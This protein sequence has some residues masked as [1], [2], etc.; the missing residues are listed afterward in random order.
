MRQFGVR[1]RF[2]KRAVNGNEK[3]QRP[4]RDADQR[5][6]AAG[7]RRSQ[8]RHHE[9]HRERKVERTQFARGVQRNP[10]PC[11]PQHERRNDDDRLGER[12]RH[13]TTTDQPPAQRTTATRH[14]VRKHGA[15]DLRR[16]IR[17]RLGRCQADTP[18]EP[19]SG[20]LPVA[21]I[22]TRREVLVERSQGSGLLA[23]QPRR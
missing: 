9:P 14:P 11:P 16:P 1:R 3:D 10:S 8:R 23:V 6:H 22:D 18:S 17:N 20:I 5:Q 19:V 2:T 21:A 12:G 15:D 4:G 7:V 13:K